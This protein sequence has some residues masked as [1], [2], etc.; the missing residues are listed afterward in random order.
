MDISSVPMNSFAMLAQSSLMAI[1]VF[2]D[3]LNYQWHNQGWREQFHL[4]VIDSGQPYDLGWSG[5]PK[6]WRSHITRALGG[7]SRTIHQD[8]IKLPNGSLA[9]FTGTFEACPTD[10]TAA[11]THPANCVL[12]Q[13]TCVTAQVQA[14]TWSKLVHAS[15]QSLMET[16]P[17]GIF[18]NNAQGQCIY[19]NAQ[20]CILTG[21]SLEEIQYRGWLEAIHPDD[22]DRVMAEWR[23]A[24]EVGQWFQSEYRFLR[25]DG[26]SRW[27]Y[28][29]AQG[30]GELGKGG[31]VGTCTDVTQRRQT[32]TTLRRYQQ[33]V[34]SASD[35]IAILDAQG[36]VLD[37]NPAWYRLHGCQTLTAIQHQ[38]L[39]IFL[40]DPI[41][42]QGIFSTVMAGQAWQHELEFADCQGNLVPVFLRV[43]PILN[44]AR[45]IT[46]LV[47]IATDISEHKRIEGE[48]RQFTD[49]LQQQVE[50]E[51][52]L[53]QLSN[54]IRQSLETPITEIISL[55]IAEIRQ[56]FDI[57]RT[58]FIWYRAHP[59]NPRWE[60]LT[61]SCAPD[62]T[63]IAVEQYTGLPWWEITQQL[64]AQDTLQLEA[65]VGNT[66]M[67]EALLSQLGYEAL[68]IVPLAVQG[69]TTGAILC[70]HSSM[71]RWSDPEV[72]LL[73][74]VVNQLAIATTQTRLYTE[75]Q[76][77]AKELETALYELSNTQSQ[78]IQTEKMSS[79]GQLVAGV[80]HEINNPVN[81]IY[82]NV[83]HAHGYIEDLLEL[84]AIYQAE[85]PEPSIAI[86][87]KREDI[88]LDFLAIDLPKLLK[89]MKV[90]VDRIKGIVTSL[91]TF[92]RMD[93]ADMKAVDIHD[94]I[95]STLLIL[96]HRLKARTNSP[97]IE[98]LRD[99]DT[100]PDVECYAGQLNQVFMNLLSNAI[101]AL[102]ETS[103]SPS[104][105]IRTRLTTPK[106]VQIQFQDNGLGIPEEHH[107]RLFDPFF[108]TK[109]IGKG[110]GLGLSISYQ[111]VTERHGGRIECQ[112][113]VGQGTTFTVTIPIRQ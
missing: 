113:I 44:E 39:G 53:N 50:R 57:D 106:I 12:V 38:N 93:E 4:P 43:S 34:E 87:E 8:C 71:H 85:Y 66:A 67:G 105:Q 101:D 90:G 10:T 88:E 7:E 94:G 18:Y 82:G 29:Q 110:T 80:A 70:G 15:P 108:T 73:Q 49:R 30:N 69:K 112:S 22:R 86:R 17:V 68:L 37:A 109:E 60:V 75:T 111:I 27:V 103:T 77:K 74:A 95:E 58:Q 32:E 55:A 13:M 102:D 98:V 41:A 83:T 63:A 5:F 47:S 19:A 84:L 3:Q 6:A 62:I 89:S 46:G 31:Y 104:I 26:S 54:Q 76:A 99:Y 23:A 14:E 11:N 25:P 33:A 9:W 92:S 35:A 21:L 64:L 65:A 100:L 24:Q 1:A 96:Q 2:D 28:S 79:L 78:L 36:C 45:Q 40:S 72:L 48:L 16:S 52:L 81:F 61:E 97:P 56:R 91:R 59:S 51:Q 42:I 107:R 20:F